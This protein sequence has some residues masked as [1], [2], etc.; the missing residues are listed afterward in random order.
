MKLITILL[1]LFTSQMSFAQVKNTFFGKTS[2]IEFGV[3]GHTNTF[4]RMPFLTIYYNEPISRE[5]IPL[6]DNEYYLNF[7]KQYDDNIALG[8]Q[9]KIGFHQ[10]FLP[11]ET[12]DYLK[13][14]VDLQTGQSQFGNYTLNY[15]YSKYKTVSIV[16]TLTFTRGGISK[17]FGPYLQLGV[18]PNFHFLENNKELV[19]TT[20][21][22]FNNNQTIDTYNLALDKEGSVKVGLMAMIG[23]GTRIP[24]TEKLALN[25]S[26][27]FYLNNIFGLSKISYGFNGNSQL[28]TYFNSIDYKNILFT[29]IRRENLRRI[30]T[31]NIGVCY[32][33]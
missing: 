11:F 5:L 22:Y 8:I 15:E 12:D 26:V 16:P 1:I 18:G 7:S 13:S 9:T 33:F 19:I 27:N 21:D 6:F 4:N 30:S 3:T 14:R 32:S 29:D 17:P 25:A 20:T 2:F 10:I 31:L 24:L 23:Y 28:L